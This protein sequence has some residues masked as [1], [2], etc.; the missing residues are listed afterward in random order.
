MQ[1]MIRS[2]A[3][4]I[5]LLY[6]DNH[7]LVV[8]KPANLPTQA[9]ASGGGKTAG[10]D[11]NQTEK[12]VGF[13]IAFEIAEEF[14]AC[15]EADRGNK[16]YQAEAFDQRKAAGEIVRRGRT[17]KYQ[18]G[19]IHMEEQSTENQCDDKHTRITQGDALDGDSAQRVAY[20]QNGEYHEQN[21]GNI[22]N[23]D[24]SVK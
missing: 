7:L 9:D 20:R 12:N 4:S 23:G 16:E 8:V 17:G 10:Q 21:R 5:P 13:E 19:V 14:R 1:E 22:A 15:D 3:F 24:N 2:G 18:S 6:E 11:D